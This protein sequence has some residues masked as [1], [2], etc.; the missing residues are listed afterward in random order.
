MLQI[1]HKIKF[2]NHHYYH[3]YIKIHNKLEQHKKEY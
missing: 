1:F 3:Q 2:N